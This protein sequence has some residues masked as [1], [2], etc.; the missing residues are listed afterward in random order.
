MNADNM[1][2]SERAFY[3][4]TKMKYLT[5][6]FMSGLSMIALAGCSIY[7]GMSKAQALL[8]RDAVDNEK[9]ADTSLSSGYGK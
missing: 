5:S 3:E 7:S 1:Q 9:E 4:Q 2:Y 6:F 8:E